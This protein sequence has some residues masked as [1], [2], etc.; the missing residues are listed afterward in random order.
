MSE[1]ISGRK[2]P[3]R[4]PLAATKKKIYIINYDILSSWRKWLSR[5]KP[6]LIIIDEVHKIK[7]ANSKRARATKRLC[8]TVPHIIAIS[9]TPLVNDRPIELFPTLNILRPDKF[10]S[11]YSFANKYSHRESKPWGPVYTGARN[12]KLLHRRLKKYVM[13]RRLKKD[14]LTE[15]PAKTR[16]VVPLPIETPRE[17]A[18]AKKD[19]VKWLLKQGKKG[20]AFRASKSLMLSRVGHLK[21]LAAKLKLKAVMEWIDDFLEN[22]TEKLIVFGI[23]RVILE[24]LKEKYKDQCV[25][26]DGRVKGIDRQHA[27]DKFMHKKKCRIFFGNIHAAGVGLTLTV[28]STVVFAELDWVPA[29]HVQAE[30]RAHRIGQLE[31]VI[32]YYL[33]A[34]GTIEESMVDI[35]QEKMNKIYAILDGEKAVSDFSIADMLARELRKAA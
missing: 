13:V 9:G 16:C 27:V 5:L 15:L 14:V 34:K 12:K 18:A 24:A 19:L 31:S 8:K 26:V 21:R 28:A 30:D 10:N 29:N 4:S 22:T 3:K 35:L 11:F 7:N 32:V 6:Q 33:V 1:V 2:A 20:A 25:L 17:Y 23:H